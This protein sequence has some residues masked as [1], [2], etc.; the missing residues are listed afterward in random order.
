LSAAVLFCRALN[1]L[2]V[3]LYERGLELLEQN[4]QQLSAAEALQELPVPHIDDGSSEDG[5]D[6]D[7]D[8]DGE[9]FDDWEEGEYG[10]YGFLDEY[11]ED[12]LLVDPDQAL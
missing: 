11:Y 6:E 9:E 2:D 10:T 5:D 8:D 1:A 7:A 12:E 4:R 3:K